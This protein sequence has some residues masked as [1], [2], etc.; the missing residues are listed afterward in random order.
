MVGNVGHD[1][2][3]P[4]SDSTHSRTTSGMACHH[5]LWEAHTIERHRA[6]HAIIT[7]GLADTVERRRAWHA[8]IA[9]GLD[10]TVRRRRAWHAIIALGRQ[11]RSNDVRHVMQTS[12]LGRTHGWTASGVACHHRLWEAHTVERR[13]AWYAII[14]FRKHTRSND[15]GRA[16]L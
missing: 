2:T 11:T 15:V 1:M 4:P 6:W 10:D 7:F 8:I 14:A 12:P 9:F 3:S 16:M 13:W 5:R